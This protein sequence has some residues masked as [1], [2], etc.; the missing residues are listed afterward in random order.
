MYPTAVGANG[1]FNPYS[2]GSDGA[3]NFTM[4]TETTTDAT[5]TFTSVF[6]G[7]M[8]TIAGNGA[9]FK[10]QYGYL[11]AT[12]WVSPND[13]TWPAFW[14]LSPTKNMEIDII[15]QYGH[16]P[17]H[18][19]GTVSD[20]NIPISST[21]RHPMEFPSA[22]QNLTTA[23][24]QYGLL[25]DAGH[26]SFY[27]DRNLQWSIATPP[28]AKQPMYMLL[29]QGSGGGWPTC[30]GPSQVGV[31]PPVAGTSCG[32]GPGQLEGAQLLVQSVNV[33]QH[34]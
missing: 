24:H 8:T 23:Y 17:N 1:P 6:S 14:M 32:S 16:D 20:Y 28:D 9:G 3:L 5:H 11:E 2:N 7:V 13:G 31:S 27:L 21:N 34:N 12:M 25:W 22:G 15:E 29:D 10:Q 30:A 18:Y 26:V 33:W 19:W 4:H